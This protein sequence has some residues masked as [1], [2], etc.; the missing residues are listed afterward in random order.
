MPSPEAEI[1]SAAG[2]D[3]EWSMKIF[4]PDFSKLDDSGEGTPTV[5]VYELS[6]VDGAPTPETVEALTGGVMDNLTQLPGFLLQTGDSGRSIRLRN[7]GQD[8]RREMMAQMEEIDAEME[9]A[10]GEKRDAAEW[11]ELTYPR[12]GQPDT[13]RSPWWVDSG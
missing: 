11:P 9:V 7:F 13:T 5:R 2:S 1:D 3:A 4:L 12:I 6:F 8:V 10:R